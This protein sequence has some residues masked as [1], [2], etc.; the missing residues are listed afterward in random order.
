MTPAKLNEQQPLANNSVNR[1]A[2]QQLTINSK[3]NSQ[4]NSQLD[5][6]RLAEQQET[7]RVTDLF[8]T[9]VFK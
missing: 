3:P 5:A 6:K 1:S 4:T 2:P 7:K 8:H 9:I